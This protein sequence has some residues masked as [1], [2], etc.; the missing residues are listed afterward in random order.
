VNGFVLRRESD[1]CGAAD[2]CLK[3]GLDVSGHSASDRIIAFL[4]NTAQH[5]LL[6]S[7]PKT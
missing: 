6:V 2:G 5:F 4:P 7:Y 1:M 3:Y